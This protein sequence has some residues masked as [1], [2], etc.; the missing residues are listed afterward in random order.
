MKISQKLIILFLLMALIPIVAIGAFSYLN[1]QRALNQEIS[2]QLTNTLNRKTEAINQIIQQNG[3]V[4]EV[5]A[6]YGNVRLLTGAYNDAPSA[7]TANQLNQV[8]A[9]R[10]ADN[11]GIRRIHVLDL[12]GK[13]EA[14]T[15]RRF[16]GLDYSKTSV[17]QKGSKGINLSMFFKD[18]DGLPAEYLTGPIVLQGKTVGVAVLEY[19]VDSLSFITGDYVD[20]GQTGESFLVAPNDQGKQ[21]NAA[22]LRFNDQAALSTYR[23]SGNGR[24]TRDYRGHLVLQRTA[25]IPDT[26]WLVGVKMDQDEV[27]APVYQLRN[28][29]LGIILVTVVLVVL[30]GWY[31]SHYITAPIIRFTQVVARIRA[32]NLNE[33]V[34]IESHD[35]IGLLGTAFNEM[36]S[37]LLESQARLMASVLGLS[38]GFIMADHDGKV[39]TI[40]LAA[41][42]LLK[43]PES[44][45]ATY[46]LRELFAKVDKFDVTSSVAQCLQGKKAL[47]ARDVTFEG[48]F[49]NIFLSPIIIGDQ[50]SGAVVLITDETE[51]RIIQRSRDEFF[52]IASHELRTPLTAIRGNTE[53]MLQYCQDQLKDPDVQS[54]ITDMHDA[55]IRLIDI[56]NDFLDMSS[57]EQGNATFTIAPFNAEE[58]AKAAIAE[59]G[60]AATAKQLPIKLELPK[61]TLPLVLADE[62]RVQ[63][64]LLALLDNAIKFTDQGTLT[65]TLEPTD[66]TMH[67]SV[68]DTGRGISPEAQKLLFHKFQQATASILTRDD[69]SATGLGLYI[70]RLLAQGM[71]GTLYL[72][73]TEEGK[74][75][76]FTLELPLADANQPNAATQR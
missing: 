69:T 25:K 26:G 21:V 10:R 15:D 48:S 7:A 6:D 68:A 75:T 36:T 63:K 2:T 46:T 43:L 62:E 5:F 70:S 64:I 41:R 71:Q 34:Q 17:F 9:V 61:T 44:G 58:V 42:R 22:P 39:I 60:K 28:L 54:M 3:T 35:E 50:T 33:R 13:V 12:H 65:V 32:G 19:Q 23:H 11:A 29:T 20:L 52:S 76:T 4:L 67:L 55:S 51:E 37:N 8:L 45:S 66:T 40:N 24:S 74:G 49:F 47:E 30:V 27:Y 53:T 14:S 31:F 38:Q 57:L 56:V 73:S 18:I 59:A 16:M 72:A 1:S